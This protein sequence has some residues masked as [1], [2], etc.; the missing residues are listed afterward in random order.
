MK[1]FLI[2]VFLNPKIA[3]VL[4]TIILAFTFLVLYANTDIYTFNILGILSAIYPSILII[5][6]MVQAWIIFPIQSLIN[7]IKNKK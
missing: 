5:I 2:N 3:I 4:I 7:Y 1:K 6:S